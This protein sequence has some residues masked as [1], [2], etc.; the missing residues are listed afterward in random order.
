MARDREEAEQLLREIEALRL[1][2]TSL[3]N[4]EDADGRK[5]RTVPKIPPGTRHG[6]KNVSAG[7]GE[8]TSRALLNATA[9]S[10]VLIDQD[11]IVIDA[12]DNI[13]ASLD[14]PRDRLIG[15]VIY[16]H[17]QPDIANQRKEKE[18]E[19]ARKKK[20]VRFI[21]FRDGRWL[22]NSVYPVFD[23][24]EKLSQFAIFSRDITNYIQVEH[25][26]KQERDRANTYLELAEVML[27]ALDRN[28]CVR[29]VNRKGCHILGCGRE[30]VL[31]KN[32]LDSF[33][34]DSIR[35]EIEDIFSH[36]IDGLIP[37]PDYYETPIRTLSGE[38]RII[39]W[40]STVMFDDAGQ[41]AGTLSSGTDITEQKLAET[42]LRESESYYRTLFES[43]SDAIFI[44]EHTCFIEC[45]KQALI[46][47]ACTREQIL[48]KTPG[49]FSPPFQP[50]GQDSV[51]KAYRNISDVNEGIPQ[52]FEWRHQRYD[53]VEFDAEV[54]L[55][56]LDL[57]DR[58]RFM[59]I[60]RDITQRKQAETA[61]NEALAQVQ[62]MKEA[63]EAE[64]I[65]LQKE[66]RKTYL[67]GDIVGQSD[68]IQSVLSLA[69]QV[70]G[71][72][73]TVLILGETGTGKELLARAIHNMSARKNRPLVVVNCAAIPDTLVESEL[74]GREKG[75][76]TGAIARQ[77]GRFEIAHGST[78]FLDEI[79]ELSLEIQAKLLRV[80]QE[81]QIERL[82]STRTININVR[83]M[84]ATN[85]DLKQALKSGYFR[86]DLFY[87]LN[88]FPISIPPLRDRK[89]DIP[90][91]VWHF[92][93]E[94]GER[95]GKRIEK[96]PQQSIDT[97]MTHNWPGNIRELHNVIERAMIQT[98]DSVLRVTSI[99]PTRG[100][101]EEAKTLA[102]VEKQRIIE[103]LE[104][105]GWRIRGTDGTAEILGIKPTTLESRM[106]KLGIKRPKEPAR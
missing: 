95:M 62:R 60:V 54:N 97:L 48:G 15:T 90:S 78:I 35:P 3:E 68:G 51:E 17:L 26:L 10:A 59:A 106:L 82:G 47:F 101:Y 8:K 105:T 92:V 49:D 96:I 39:A 61:L 79:G 83:V 52:F 98:Q 33:L 46:M 27:I 89:E 20:L 86:E 64:N 45:N 18:K 84:A 24:D 13:A 53:G 80:L 29:L 12:N 34:P 57:K 5:S 77:I 23:S 102:D 63:A 56:P 55:T 44:M 22:E 32:F 7:D 81:G 40:H 91:L 31:G 85:R 76:F 70:A 104:Q 30:Q 11:G 93:D 21:D 73:T 58:K 99:S 71:T 88:V 69:E 74:F 14:I 6:R 75:A 28:A 1:R 43:A 103:V 42:A 65:Y 4:N 72:D 19:A 16:D 100:S 66:I 37:V 38:E 36:V 87:R 50:D 94:M 9:D 67:H 25:A 41:I 2:V